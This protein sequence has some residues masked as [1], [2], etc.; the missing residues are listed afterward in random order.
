[1]KNF[2]RTSLPAQVKYNGKT[3]EA[4]IKQ[5]SLHF[6]AGQPLPT[7]KKFITV[8]VLSRNLRGRTDL[9][10]QPYKPTKWIFTA[11]DQQLTQ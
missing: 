4:D 9:H 10:G 2:N 3:Y 5:S 8:N 7:G 6:N 1:M 11:N